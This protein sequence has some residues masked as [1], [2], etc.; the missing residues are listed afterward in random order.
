[1]DAVQG[2]TER[3]LLGVE[4]EFERVVLRSRNCEAKQKLKACQWR[5]D[6]FEEVLSSLPPRPPRRAL[7]LW[8]ACSV[9]KSC[10]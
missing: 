2:D 9:L 7:S 8:Y 10:L 5:I 4:E 1:L 3:R 6:V